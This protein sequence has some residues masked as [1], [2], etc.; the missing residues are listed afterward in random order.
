MNNKNNIK[1]IAG[2]NLT[3]EQYKK[4]LD[5]ISYYSKLNTKNVSIRECFVYLIEEKN[6]NDKSKRINNV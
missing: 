3:V 5:I 4:L 1:K 6:I 2:F